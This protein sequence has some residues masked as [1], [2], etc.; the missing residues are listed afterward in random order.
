MEIAEKEA[1]RLA[2]LYSYG[3]LDTEFEERFDRLTRLASH[4]LGAPYA[5]ISLIDKDR[6]WFK[7]SVGLKDRQTPRNISFCAH[8][9]QGAGVLVVLDTKKDH[10][11]SKNPLVT[12]NP[13]IRFYAG[14]P[15][16]GHKGQAIGTLCVMDRKPRDKFTAKEQQLLRDLTDSV[17]DMFELRLVLSKARALK[18]KS[19]TPAIR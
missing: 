2:V 7:S 8:T 10:R 16:I 15:L 17:V 14:A 5:R 19:R 1:E 11:F 9:I 13:K 4:I 3:V 12:G 18:R 6:Q